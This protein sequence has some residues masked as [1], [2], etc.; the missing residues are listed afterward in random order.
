MKSIT[1]T[2]AVLLLITWLT[3]P[4]KAQNLANNITVKGN[5]RFAI[6]LYKQLTQG[7]QSN[8]F[9]S[10]YSIS[11]AL[12]MTYAGAKQTTAT[13]MAQV[14]HFAPDNLHKDYKTLSD[15][16]KNLNTKGLELK[17][18]NALWGEK[19]Q[20]FLPDYLSLNQKYYQSKLE[21]LDFKKQPEQSRLIINKWVESKTNNK[22]KNLIPKELINHR[23][24]LVLTNAIYFKGNW[25]YKFLKRNTKKMLF[26]ANNQRFPGIK[27]MGMQ[28]RFRYTENAQLQAIEI[29][30]KDHKMSMMILLPKDKNGLNTL[31]KQL[32]LA[33]YQKLMAQ[34]FYTK[35]KLSLPKFKMTVKTNLKKT[36]KQLGMRKAF[37]KQAN[38]SGMTKHP[39]LKI[40]EVVHKAFVEVNEK[41][42]EAAAATAVIMGKESVTSTKRPILPKIFKADHPFMFIIKDNKTNSILFIGKLNKPMITS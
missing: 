38:F 6:E 35:V 1:K 9:V 11:S 30:Y 26:V 5:N 22:I 21:N 40:S 41:G 16:F 12:A 37:S 20:L 28:R 36:L 39:I 42:T 3:V 27:F 10:P 8:L 14:L 2:F 15:H 34:M 29:P 7:K 33:M 19:T 32:N 13:E 25:E 18:A 24:R 31:E 17:I 4:L 23:T